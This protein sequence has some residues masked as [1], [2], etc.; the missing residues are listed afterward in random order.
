[1]AK[2]V[3]YGKTPAAKNEFHDLHKFIEY[4]LSNSYVD[5]GTK[6][7]NTISLTG[8]VKVHGSNFGVSLSKD[9]KIRYQTRENFSDPEHNNFGN[10][11]SL[12]I[13]TIGEEK[14]RS[15]LEPHLKDAERVVIFGELFGQGIQKRVAVSHLPV[16]Y[17]VFAFYRLY[18]KE[19]TENV[20]EMLHGERVIKH[21][22]GE[23]YIEKEPLDISLIPSMPELRFYKA[24]DFKIFNVNVNIN[25]FQAAYNELMTYTLEVEEECPVGC[26]IDPD[27]ENKV[28]EGIIWTGHYYLNGHSHF[29]K[30]KTKGEKHK[31]GKGSIKQKIEDNLSDEQKEAL[32]NFYSEA[33]SFDRLEQ[34]FEYLDQLGLDV[35]MKNIP[36]YVKWVAKDVD[37]ELK[38]EIDEL[39]QLGIEFKKVIKVV[40]KKAS[41]FFIKTFK[42][43]LS[44]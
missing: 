42:D 25:D 39:N 32:N 2:L 3:K 20:Y 5:E 11:R 41:S 9:D 36:I 22:K 23:K 19:F 8:T 10:F 30:F 28:G 27:T 6:V 35:E 21:E 33:L 31:R 12:F 44:K 18:E 29:V 13:D 34:G 24:T 7:P 14:I 1:M 38:A 26:S 16:S 17:M 4:H 37:E 40:N 43:N 15:T